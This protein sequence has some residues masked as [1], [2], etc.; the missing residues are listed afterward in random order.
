MNFDFSNISLD[1][2]DG[3]EEGILVTSACLF[4]SKDLILLIGLWIVILEVNFDA[5]FCLNI[6][7][8][9]ALSE[10]HPSL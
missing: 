4:F 10:S 9:S 7:L 6:L 5:I 2:L 1:S 8:S 3:I